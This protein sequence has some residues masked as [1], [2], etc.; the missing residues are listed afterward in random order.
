MLHRA[1]S[2]RQQGFLVRLQ[3]IFSRLSMHFCI[4]LHGVPTCQANLSSGKKAKDQ[5]HVIGLHVY[6]TRICTLLCRTVQLY[7]QR[8]DMLIEQSVCSLP[9]RW[10]KRSLTNND[11]MT[12]MFSASTIST[13][14][15]PRIEVIQ[16]MLYIFTGHEAHAEHGKDWTQ[17]L[18]RLGIFLTANLH[19]LATLVILRH[20]P[21]SW[22]VRAQGFNLINCCSLSYKNTHVASDNF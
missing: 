4:H 5:L 18:S 17:R 1:F 13:I 8:V 3:S 20:Q 16:R 10:I 15:L 11:I 22:S 12:N 14:G 19:N 2:L 21:F 6:S 9:A 7:T